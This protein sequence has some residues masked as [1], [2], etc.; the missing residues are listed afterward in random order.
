M[1]RLMRFNFK[2]LRYVPALALLAVTGVIAQEK[3]AE[4][5]KPKPVPVYLGK[6][7]YRDTTISERKFDE[8]LREGLT[9]RDSL[10]NEYRV[11]SYLLTYG[12]RNLYE[13]SV[14][15]LMMLTDLLT[16]PCDSGAKPPGFLLQNIIERSKPGDTV[17]FDQVT[18]KAPEGYNAN[19]KSLRL[20]LT[21]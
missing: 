4:K 6:S 16:H 11:L 10:G 7:N 13:D 14:G 15:N 18:V 1:K 19:G 9:S 17:Y 20:V 21:K 2:K 12:E 3:K 5:P 8:L